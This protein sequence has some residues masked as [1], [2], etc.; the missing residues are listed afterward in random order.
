MK[1]SD[2]TSREVSDASYDVRRLI[3]FIGGDE[4]SE[5]ARKVCD[6]LLVGIHRVLLLPRERQFLGD[7]MKEVLEIRQMYAE[8]EK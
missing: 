7:I 1:L 8:R 2:L 3:D 5:C 4:E 6:A